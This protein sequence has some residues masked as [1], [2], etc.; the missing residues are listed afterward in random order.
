[1]DSADAFTRLRDLQEAQR[2][3]APIVGEILGMDSAATVFR[4][5]LSRLGVDHRGLPDAALPAMF[6]TARRGQHGNGGAPR[7]AQDS[8]GAASFAARFPDAARIRN[9]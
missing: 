4:E 5:A 2:E 1:M 6:R 8:R 3:V 7:I 9:V